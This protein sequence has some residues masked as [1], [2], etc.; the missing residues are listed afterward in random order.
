MDWMPSVAR[1]DA[2]KNQLCERVRKAVFALLRAGYRNAETPRRKKAETLVHDLS[3]NSS[4]FLHPELFDWYRRLRG[5]VMAKDADRLDHVVDEL[6]QVREEISSSRARAE[7]RHA[8]LNGAFDLRNDS[9]SITDALARAS[10]FVTESFGVESRLERVDVTD[11]HITSLGAAIAEL[12]AV[13]PEFA[14][15]LRQSVVKIVLFRGPTAIGFADFEHHHAIFLKE[16]YVIGADVTPT[17]LA[18]EII[19]EASHVRLNTSIA[20]QPFFENPPEELYDSPLRPDPRPMFGVYH[21][22]FVLRRLKEFYARKIAV[23][24]EEEIERCRTE[25]AAID[26]SLDAALDVIQ[27]HG[28]L[29]TVGKELV[30]HVR[31]SLAAAV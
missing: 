1:T 3:D 22:M 26:E 25:E 15:E 18:E 20:V 28:Q 2:D 21:Q 31:G 27:T 30:E 29:T 19:H 14:Q 16:A 7:Q 17:S 12:D 8:Q 9:P 10:R 24:N 13:W 4:V 5:A 6:P 11:E 23:S